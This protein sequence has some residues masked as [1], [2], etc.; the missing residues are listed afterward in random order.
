MARKGK[1]IT[2]VTTKAGDSGSTTLADGSKIAKT[3]P[4][5]HAIGDVDELNSLVGLLVTELPANGPL[6]QACSRLQQELF[7]LGGHLATEG[8]F[9]CP[10]ALW[11][12][13]LVAELNAALPELAEFV[14]PG[15]T[16]TAALAHVCRT[17]CRR[18][19]R[20]LWDVDDAADAAVYANRL[21]DV[22]FQMARTLNEGI[23][24]QWRG[25]QGE[26]PDVS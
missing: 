1:R 14:I 2:R 9:P 24:P 10:D 12:E 15:G 8:E 5:M 16:R 17:T 25:S 3:H 4:R 7:D 6:A 19:E 11:L 23:E 20:T 13:E 22:F 26:P 21:S 18:A